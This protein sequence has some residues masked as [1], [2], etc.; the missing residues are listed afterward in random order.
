MLFILVFFALAPGFA[1]ALLIRL[2]QRLVR[3]PRLRWAIAAVGA[4]A[5]G[6]WAGAS[7]AMFFLVF[8]Q[9]WGLAHQQRPSP[10]LFPEG[11]LVYAF[12]V[13]YAALG[14]VLLTGASKVPARPK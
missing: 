13:A 10:G 2:V 6:T 5:L 9:A 3:E 4:C 8:G 12:L 14:T 11:W 1:L 7:W